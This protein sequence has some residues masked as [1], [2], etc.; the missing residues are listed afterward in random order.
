MA[1]GFLAGRDASD[2]TLLQRGWDWLEGYD[3]ASKK[4]RFD[5][6]W[7]WLRGYRRDGDLESTHW[8]RT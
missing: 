5:R 6:S 8:S 3:P 1:W 2:R 4:T 7:D